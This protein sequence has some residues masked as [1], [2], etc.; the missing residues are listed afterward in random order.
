MNQQYSKKLKIRQLETRRVWGVLR[1]EG[2]RVYEERRL[3]GGWLVVGWLVVG[4][5]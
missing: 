4:G 3:V 2:R 1:E 5:Q